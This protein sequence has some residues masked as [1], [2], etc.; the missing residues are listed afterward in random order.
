VIF[1]HDCL[2]LSTQLTLLGVCWLAEVALRN[3]AQSIAS[4]LQNSTQTLRRCA[5]LPVSV[6]LELHL[7]L[8]LAV[9]LLAVQLLAVEPLPRI[10]LPGLVLPLRLR[11]RRLVLGVLVPVPEPYLLQGRDRTFDH[12]LALLQL[13]IEYKF[14]KNSQSIQPSGTIGL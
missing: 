10:L 11:P 13:L 5:G 6:R 3:C 14:A 1:C 2:L 9:R 12:Q 7:F 4:C 8:L